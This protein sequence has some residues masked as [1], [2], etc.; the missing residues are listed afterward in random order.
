M[1]TK[2]KF[3]TSLLICSVSLFSLTQATFA[4]LTTNKYIDKIEF[5]TE[6]GRLNIEAMM[7]VQDRNNGTVVRINDTP[8]YIAQTNTQNEIDVGYIFDDVHEI[9]F[10]LLNFVGDQ[11]SLNTLKIPAYYIE[12]Q[13]FTT[14]Q[15]S[16]LQVSLNTTSYVNDEVVPNF[17]NYEFRHLS[18]YNSTATPL[19]Y[20]THSSL[21]LLNAQVGRPLNATPSYLTIGADANYGYEL[22]ITSDA[23][24]FYESHFLKSFIIKINPDYLAFYNYLKT[25]TDYGNQNKLIGTKFV[26]TINYSEVPFV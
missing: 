21:D 3:I 7:F 12:F 22:S 11:Y 14:I 20:A 6:K 25:Q 8:E 10:D 26:V 9:D 19:S 13:V 16:Y 5:Q 15:L 1:K 17:S 24:V 23:S 4:W 18:V 2:Y